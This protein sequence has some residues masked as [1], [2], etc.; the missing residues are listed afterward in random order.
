MFRVL[1]AVCCFMCVRPIGELDKFREEM[2]TRAADPFSVVL[3]RKKL[4]MSL[5]QEPSK[6]CEYGVHV[7]T[8]IIYC[9]RSMYIQYV[10]KG[11]SPTC[12]YLRTP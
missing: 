8:N 12:M 10:L 1:C 7:Y 4:P 5:L 11:A 6:V 3:K 2:T 9:T